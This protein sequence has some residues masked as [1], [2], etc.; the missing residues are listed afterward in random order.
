MIRTHFRA[1]LAA[2]AL[3][4]AAGGCGGPKLIEVEG[5]LRQQGKPLDNVRVAFVPEGGGPRS[6]GVTDAQGHYRLA[7]DQQRPGA[8][9]GS[10]RVVLT[11]LYVYGTKFVGRAREELPEG[12]LVGVKPSRI[13]P[14]YTDAARTPLKKDVVAGQKNAIDLEVPPR[15]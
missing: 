11:D 6:S 8:I 13:P 3:A 7:T 10:S 15:K 2:A 14:D 1:A 12:G 5:T 9:V 4:V